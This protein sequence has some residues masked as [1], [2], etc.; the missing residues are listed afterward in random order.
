VCG[1]YRDERIS[2]KDCLVV[3]RA[4]DERCGDERI[5]D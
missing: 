3:G 5:R 1:D 2:V 4:G